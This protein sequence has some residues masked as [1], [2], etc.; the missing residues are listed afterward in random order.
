[1]ESLAGGSNAVDVFA[2]GGA[3]GQGSR[4]SQEDHYIIH[5]SGDLPSEY[6]D[7]HALFAVFDGHGG[8]IVSKHAKTH[9]AD[10][11]F[12]SPSFKSGN[13]EDA[14]QEAIN[15]EDELLLKEF[16]QGENAYALAGSTASIALL[17]LKRGVLVVGNVGDSH[18]IL[19][20]RDSG[21][22]HV[23]GVDRLTTSHK[24]ENPEEKE[25]IEQA[26]GQIHEQHAIT[27]IGSL[28]MSRA[29]GDLQYK[30]P[31]IAITSVDQTDA[32]EV[33]TN[34][35]SSHTE[36]LITVQI[37]SRRVELG[38]DKQYM[39]ALTTDGITN[40]IDDNKLMSNM[41]GL[42]NRGGNAE[43]VAGAMVNEAT[44]RPQSDN[45]TC[46]AVV[47]NGV[48]APFNQGEGVETAI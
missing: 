33:A 40:V 46:V 13:Y 23:R 2:V 16:Q 1:M 31:L 17:D 21:S 24:P 35:H 20:E 45:S 37:S 3:N 47:L 14:I 19:A 25:R 28:N 4:P 26:G 30:T 5:T 42:F 43:Q 10:L 34:E 8:E 11:I 48:D 9:I 12:S 38:K 18:I 39:L 36:D 41:M 27:R 15:K 44:G 22:G 6:K 7:T 29:L 32:Q